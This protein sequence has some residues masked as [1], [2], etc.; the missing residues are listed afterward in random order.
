[1]ARRAR[2]I[3]KRP[4]KGLIRP[5]K[6]LIRPLRR[7]GKFQR[8]SRTPPTISDE[9]RVCCL[10]KMRRLRPFKVLLRPYEGLLRLVKVKFVD[11]CRGY[12]GDFGGCFGSFRWRAERA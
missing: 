11:D 12:F 3:I 6:G 5:F 10:Y 1:M 7:C 2:L 8:N 4:F 9:R